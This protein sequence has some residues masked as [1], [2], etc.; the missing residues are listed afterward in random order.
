MNRLFAR[1]CRKLTQ[2]ISRRLPERYRR[3]DSGLTT[4]EWLLIVAAVAGLAAL[5]VVLVTNVVG[6]TG[7]Q[8]SG[9]S[10]R[11]TAAEL[12]AAEVV[13]RAQTADVTDA[14]WDSPAKWAT[15]Y[16]EQCRRVAVTYS[17][18]GI[19]VTPMFDGVTNDANH[20]AANLLTADAAVATATKPQAS[21]AVT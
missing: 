15:Y 19:T 20:N 9:Q 7:E 16:S 11:R 4:L 2:T 12:A 14:R 6:Q 8:I 21:C 3:D 1:T 5:A 10:A 18:A 13:R 17:D